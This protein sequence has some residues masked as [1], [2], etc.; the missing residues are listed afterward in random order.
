MIHLRVDIPAR[1]RDDTSPPEPIT[2]ET[3]DGIRDHLIDK[4]LSE[5]IDVTDHFHDQVYAVRPWPT[6]GPDDLPPEVRD[7]NDGL[8]LE[9]AAAVYKISPAH[10]T[11]SEKGRDRSK[12]TPDPQTPASKKRPSKSGDVTFSNPESPEPVKAD[13]DADTDPVFQ[14][15]SDNGLVG[16]VR[17]VRKLFR[18]R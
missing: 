8:V 9:L 4:A 2:A 16:V 5:R 17:N 11:L 3:L 1:D 10:I 6:A 15:P 14:E 18:Q 7:V 12:S 13:P